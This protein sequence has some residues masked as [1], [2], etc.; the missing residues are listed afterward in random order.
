MN[1]LILLVYFTD[2]RG[3]RVQFQPIEEEEV[4]E[5]FKSPKEDTSDSSSIIDQAELE[6]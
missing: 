1:V 4:F 2:R 5:E 6:R 3:K